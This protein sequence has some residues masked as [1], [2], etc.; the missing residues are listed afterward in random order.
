MLACQSSPQ[1]RS[2]RSAAEDGLIKPRNGI[3]WNGMDFVNKE[4]TLQHK[5]EEKIQ[6]ESLFQE[7]MG[8]QY[9]SANCIKT[10]M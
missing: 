10:L 8:S 7:M 1:E 3:E 2:V 4:W 6:I 9:I 5:L